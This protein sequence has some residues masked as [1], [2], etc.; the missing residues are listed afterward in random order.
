MIAILTTI[1]NRQKENTAK[2]VFLFWGRGISQY[3]D[4]KKN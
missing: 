1:Q 3:G 4:E 2:K